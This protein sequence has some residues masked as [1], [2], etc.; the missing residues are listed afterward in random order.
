ML[1]ARCKEHHGRQSHTPSAPP[2][3]DRCRHL[4]RYRRRPWSGRPT[5]RCRFTTGS[6]ASPVTAA[7]RRSRPRC[8]TKVIDRKVTVR[9]DANVGAGLAVALRARTEFDRGEARRS[10]HRPLSRHQRGGAADHRSGRLQ[11]RAAD[12]RF[13]FPEDQLLLLH[14]AAAEGRREAGHDGGV[15][16]RSGDDQG[17]RRRRPSTPSRCPTPSTSCTSHR[18]RWRT[19]SR[20]AGA[21]RFEA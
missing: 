14:R 10:R 20:R 8:P 16:R 7:P 2:R 18:R 15:L 12:G 3:R 5:L 1:T 9:F 17:S 19:T 11:R 13:V 6:A 4:R 21:D